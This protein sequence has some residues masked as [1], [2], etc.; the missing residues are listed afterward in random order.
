V[1]AYRQGGDLGVTF[2]GFVIEKQSAK[3]K[4]K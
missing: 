1:L 4:R 3:K 2:G